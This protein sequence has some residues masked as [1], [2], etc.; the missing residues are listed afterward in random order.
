MVEVEPEG[1]IDRITDAQSTTSIDNV[2]ATSIDKVREASSVP[3]NRQLWLDLRSTS[4]SPYEAVGFLRQVLV[5]EDMEGQEQNENFVENSIDRI[6]L[7]EDVFL[8][9]LNSKNDALQDMDFSYAVQDDLIHSSREEGHSFP[10]GKILSCKP[11]TV[12]DPM[13][14]LDTVSKGGWVVVD[15]DDEADEAVL[16]KAQQV[17]SLLQFLSS[18]ST[19]SSTGP[20]SLFLPGISES[21]AT[22]RGGIAICC[23]TKNFL[24]QTATALQQLRCADMITTSTESGIILSTGMSAR[25]AGSQPLKA[26]LVLPF[27]LQLWKIALDLQQMEEDQDLY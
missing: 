17:S 19:S 3:S 8:K 18:A 25:P 7:S 1:S 13:L 14:A 16:R 20:D 4:L 2:K 27:D 26:A 5:E 11:D 6:L 21:I 9:V 23:S 22:T 10:M 15:S 12:L 24:L